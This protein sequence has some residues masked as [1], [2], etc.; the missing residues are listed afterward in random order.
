MEEELIKKQKKHLFIGFLLAFAFLFTLLGLT[1]FQAINLS[2]YQGVDED[3]KATVD[4]TNTLEREIQFLKRSETQALQPPF[5]NNLPEN[6][7]SAPRDFQQITLLRD[8]EGT[9]LNQSALGL[10]YEEFSE[11]PFSKNDLKHIT[12]I[13]LVDSTGTLHHF[14]EI[15]VAASS[16]QSTE[17]AYLQVLVNTDQLQTSMGHFKIILLI[18]MLFAFLLAVFLSRYLTN[19]AL[20]PIVVGWQKQQDFVAN[21][22]HELRT[23]LSVM[24]SQLEGL[25]LKPN[26]TILEVSE[27]IATTLSEIRRLTKLSN[28][29]LLLAKFDAEK[30]ASEKSWEEPAVFLQ[31]F[32]EPYEEL[33][34]SEGKTLTLTNTFSGKVLF[35]ANQMQQVLLILLDNAL[36]YTK[37]GGQI[38]IV[39]QKTEKGWQVAVKDDGLGF[40]EENPELLFERFYRADRARST[41]GTGLGLAIAKTIIDSHHGKITAEK[42]IPQGGIFTWWIP[43]KG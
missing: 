14:H 40:Q 4:D 8:E 35:D 9:I 23:P 41:K 33:A 25:F 26:Q 12:S 29:L 18:S 28:D 22:S 7:E 43:L 3:L 19:R 20:K 21:A 5:A 36:K 6:K 31:K 2:M 38:E 24:Q 13:E 11:V 34:K 1:V 39:S 37:E 27:P 16:P 42:N 17:V 15:T 32:K 10:R 30:F